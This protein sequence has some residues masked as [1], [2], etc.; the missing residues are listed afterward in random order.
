MAATGFWIGLVLGLT[1]AAVLLSWSLHALSL[2]RARQQRAPAPL[3][4]TP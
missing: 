3:A 2:Q 1:I 4:V